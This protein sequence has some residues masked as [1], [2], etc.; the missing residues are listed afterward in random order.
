MSSSR[1][2]L[3]VV[4]A[5]GSVRIQEVAREEQDFVPQYVLD[6]VPARPREP[7]LPR[8]WLEFEEATEE[9]L[10]AFEERHRQES[11]EQYEHGVQEGMR[12]RDAEVQKRLQAA[13][14][15]FKDLLAKVELHL[16]RQQ[17]DTYRQAAKLAAALAT[18][19]LGRLVQLNETAFLAALED[20]MAPL[21]HLDDI[22]ARL[23]PADCE[24]LKAGIAS[25]DELFG[26]CASLKI[27]ADPDVERGGAVT[28]SSG[29]SVDARMATRIERALEAIVVDHDD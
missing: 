22:T 23:H 5:Q 14:V 2:L 11:A 24:V 18:A 20:A 19:W 4:L 6:P 7:R 9:R 25:G 15:P 29:G 1:P 17:H 28:T 21:S 10:A 16:S 27:V 12:R 13:A 26:S 3:E 8:S